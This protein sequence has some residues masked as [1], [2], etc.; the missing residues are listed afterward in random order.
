MK[1]WDRRNLS[2]ALHSFRPHNKPIMR[3]EWAP[4]KKGKLPTR[5]P[6]LHCTCVLLPR[7]SYY[8]L[9]LFW[10]YAPT[11]RSRMAVAGGS[12]LSRFAAVQVCLRAV[13]RT[14]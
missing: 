6:L 9:L 7:A 10:A 12:F 2:S 4:Y 11:G 5:P 13:G 3:V 1:V 8:A 14:S